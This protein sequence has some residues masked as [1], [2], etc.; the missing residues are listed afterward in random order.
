ME[1]NEDFPTPSGDNK[2]DTSSFKK[3]FNKRF[4][5]EDEQKPEQENLKE[6]E[7]SV[8]QITQSEVQ[9]KLNRKID[10]PELLTWMQEKGIEFDSGNIEIEVGGV[11]HMMNT[12]KDDFGTLN[13]TEDN[14]TE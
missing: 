4:G 7:L 11:K 6:G 9:E 3:M 8:I 1:F 10:D 12:S 5:N 14:I 13:Y 2:P